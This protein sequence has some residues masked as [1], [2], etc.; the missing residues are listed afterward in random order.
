[1][2][3][4]D[5]VVGVVASGV[6]RAYP[7]W[8]AK[9]YH[10][11]NDV[12]GDTAVAIAFC[13]QC[14]GAAA[15]RRRLNGRLLSMEVPGVYNGTIVLRDRETGT[16]WAPFSGRALE[17]PL[18]GRKLDRI[19]VSLTRWGEWKSRHPQ[20]GV[21][22]APEEGRDGHGS[23]YEPGKWGIVS[24]MG[25]TIENWDARLPENALVYGVDIEE[26]ARSYPIAEIEAR[27]GLVNDLFRGVP[28]IIR[29]RGDLEVVGF[30]RRV[31]G[32]ILTFDTPP[33]RENAMI[34]RE[35]GSVWSWD[36]QALRGPLRGER[37]ASLDGYVVEWH[38]WSTSNPKTEIFGVSEA[39]GVRAAA[40][41]PMFPGVAIFP[42]EGER[43]V[44][45]QLKGKISLVVLW[46]A[47][48]PPCRVEMPKLQALV[49]TH[50]GQGLSALGIAVHI[51]DTGER[52]L[53]RS[54][55]SDAKVTFTNGLIT[56]PAYDRLEAL[57]R[58][59]GRPGLILPTVFVV[60]K[61]RRV[62]AVFSGSEVDALPATLSGLLK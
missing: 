27:S 52:D 6:A 38:V 55:L 17:G 23:W 5:P 48:C 32:R 47:W 36:G 21:V 62:R 50:S 13:E 7:W 24:E 20:T 40:G 44:D 9:N 16:I 12:I 18:A 59:L 34:D 31:R 51:P 15:F 2:R 1:M 33:D 46:A 14:T 56:E 25:A 3:D 39:A 58:S 35:T 26:A 19:P 57:S 43:A 45:V 8:V 49:T 22:W 60:D 28:V 11:I 29:A 30:E 61:E 37:L 42:M 54:F 41:A 4:D 53:V 10:A